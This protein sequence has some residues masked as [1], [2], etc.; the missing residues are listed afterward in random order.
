[1]SP[2]QSRDRQ[3]VVWPRGRRIVEARALAPRLS[4]LEGKTLGMI[5]DYVFRGDEIFP[6]LEAALARRFPRAR[7]VP[8][9]EFGPTFGGAEHATIARLPGT[10]QRLGVDGLISGMGC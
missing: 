1:M 5:W 8:F 6:I 10:L 3:K 2:E 7:F 9:Q 4:S